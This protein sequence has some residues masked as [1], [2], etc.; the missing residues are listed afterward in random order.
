LRPK[1]F[2]LLP[3][4]QLSSC[5]AGTIV[6]DTR[7]VTLSDVDRFNHFP[8]TPLVSVTRVIE[9]DLHLINALNEAGVENHLPNLF[10]T[11]PTGK[12]TISWSRGEVYAVTMGFYPDAWLKL[13]SGLDD[14]TIPNIITQASDGFNESIGPHLSWDSFCDILLPVWSSKKTAE[15]LTDWPGSDRLTDW[16]RHLLSRI[17]MTATGRSVRTFERRLKYWT[18]STKQHLDHYAAI[19]DLHL[20]VVENPKDSL[21][22]LAIDAGYSD[23][24]HMGRAVARTTGFSPAKLNK[25]IKT[26]ESFWCYRLL[27]ERF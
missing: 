25:L 14:H 20:H 9:G 17:A 3:P 6:R 1:S 5:I 18:S 19:E 21:S 24:S 12:P 4:N 23:Q 22:G 7:G 15:G 2:F 16:S 13:C 10:V 27:G 8:A 26:E 11:H